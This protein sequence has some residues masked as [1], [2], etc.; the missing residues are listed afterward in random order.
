VHDISNVVAYSRLHYASVHEVRQKKIKCQLQLVFK[1]PSNDVCPLKLI[2]DFKPAVPSDPDNEPF[3][4]ASEFLMVQM[5]QR[6]C[7]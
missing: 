4:N 3:G 1:V 2:S 7:I 6:L 5:I